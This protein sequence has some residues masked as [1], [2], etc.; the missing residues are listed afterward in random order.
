MIFSPIGASFS[1]S[2][3]AGA[4]AETWQNWR[5]IGIVPLNNLP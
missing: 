5:R 3:W 2:G 1:G 4:G